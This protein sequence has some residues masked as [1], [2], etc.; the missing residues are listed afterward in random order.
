MAAS[1][2]VPHS[3][4]ISQI[5]KPGV[6]T[7]YGFGIRVTMQNGHLAVEDGVGPE[8]RRFLLSRI[9]QPRPS[10][11]VA[12]QGPPYLQL[13]TS[14]PLRALRRC[15]EYLHPFSPRLRAYHFFDSTAL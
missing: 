3:P 5:S 4:A 10:C 1:K 12:Q 8:R 14:M 2:T 9:G 13:P 15:A 11:T 7:L 6:L